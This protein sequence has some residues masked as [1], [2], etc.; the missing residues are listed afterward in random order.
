M[1]L[2]EFQEVGS[3]LFARGLVSSHG[4]NLSVRAGDKLIITRRASRLAH[5][6]ERD[7][8]ET[9]VDW[10][11]RATPSAS[12]ELFI[13]RFLYQRTGAHAI[14]HAHPAYAVALSL[15]ERTIQPLDAEARHNLDL[16]PVVG[17]EVVFQ[18]RTV[19][20]ELASLLRESKVVVVR[21]HGTFAVGQLLEEAHRWTSL[22]EECCKLIT[23]YRQLEASQREGR[24]SIEEIASTIGGP[25]P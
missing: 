19:A 18:V 23:I 25:R 24:P 17:D 16:V 15:C 14:V 10:N 7:M 5:L 13:H 2:Q 11:D 8:V 12:S 3:D 4:G 20:E 9:G 21:G 22:L 6:R 1:R